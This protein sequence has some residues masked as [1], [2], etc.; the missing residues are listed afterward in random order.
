M[1]NL[2]I[3]FTGE[4]SFCEK[5]PLS[6]ICYTLSV[7]IGLHGVVGTEAE[8]LNGVV[9]R[10]EPRLGGDLF[11]PLLDGPALDLD[12]AAA[13]PA[14]Q[15]VVVPGRA[16]LPVEGL[17]RGVADRVDRALLAEHLE[18]AVDGGEPDGLALTAQFG[19]DLLGAAEP[20]KA[21]EGGGDDRGLPR[22]AYP[23]PPRLIRCHILQS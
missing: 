19:V 3:R 21:R 14:C 22:P 6:L 16:A 11:R 13:D 8:E 9:D 18:V 1:R 23:G 2:S 5:V 7:L 4:C 17:A 20:G 15:V 12:A 10:R